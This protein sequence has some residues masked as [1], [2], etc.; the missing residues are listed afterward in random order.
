MM[1]IENVANKATKELFAPDVAIG[2]RIA[3]HCQKRGLIVRPIAHLNVMSPPLIL[4]RSQI[5]TMVGILQESI[6]AT[7]DELVKEDLWHG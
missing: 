6:E 4:D 3:N 2:D 5:D 1:C 7:M